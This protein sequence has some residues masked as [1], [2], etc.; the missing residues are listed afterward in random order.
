MCMSLLQDQ[1][2]MFDAT[3]PCLPSRLVLRVPSS[4]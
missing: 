2:Y 1:I 3:K 4:S